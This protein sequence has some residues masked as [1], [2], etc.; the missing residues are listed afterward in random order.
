VDSFETI[1]RRIEQL[2]GDEFRQK[3]G[4]TFTY[5]VD[6]GSVVPSTT[7]RRLPKGDF[8]KAFERRPLPGPGAIND[9][10]GPSYLWAVLTDPRV[11][12]LS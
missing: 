4:R 11:A 10:Q 8:R 7:N 12:G 6:G 5:S 2:E 3:T 1:W 9:L